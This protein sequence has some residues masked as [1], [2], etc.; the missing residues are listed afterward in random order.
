MTAR[1]CAYLSLAPYHAVG[2]GNCQGVNNKNAHRDVN[3]TIY[4]SRYIGRKAILLQIEL[5]ETSSFLWRGKANGV[6]EAKHTL[7][8]NHKWSTGGKKVRSLSKIGIIIWHTRI[9]VS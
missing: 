2:S 8:K 6:Q 1:L 7:T 3:L 4:I 5:R 9:V